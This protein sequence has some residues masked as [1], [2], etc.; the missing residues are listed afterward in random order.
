VKRQPKRGWIP[1]GPAE[2][3]S[4]GGDLFG[5][6][7]ENFERYGDI[8]S[9][10]VYGS[11]VYVVSAPEYCEHILRRNWLNYPRKGLVV[12]R[13]ALALGNNLITS[14]GES[15]ATQRRMIQPAFTKGAIAYWSGMMASANAELLQEWRGAAER[16]DKINV[17]H[18]LTLMV[19]K[20]TLRSIFGDDYDTVAPHFQF[21]AADAARDLKFALNVAALRDLIL[22]IV[23][24]R[25]GQNVCAAD[26]LG[27]MMQACDRQRREHM[28]DAQLAREAVN[29]VVA[30]HETTA[31]V[32]NWIWYLLALHPEA[33]EKLAAELDGVPWEGDPTI[34]MLPNYSYTRSVIDEA[35]RLYPPLWLMTRKALSDDRLGEYFVPA[36]TEIFISP[37]LI[38][39]NPQLWEAPDRFDPDRLSPNRTLERHELALCPFGAGPRKCI[40]D[41]F[42]RAEI[43]IHLMMFGKDLRLRL[44]EGNSSEITTGVNLL[45]K[46]NFYMLPQIRSKRR[47]IRSTSPAN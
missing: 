25:R 36:G 37:F 31:S 28:A 29:L 16:R 34:D 5:W 2:H 38:Q 40:G 7:K 12:Q 4:S 44:C 23:A 45:S 39:H 26:T 46:H 35:L 19:L 8:F 17:T 30:G 11:I 47:L 3:F 33:Q 24:K 13:I 18:D 42:A 15:W 22:R 10:T 21:F 14:N 41:L 32:L 43:Q 6:I 9:A 20:I 27:I 1:L